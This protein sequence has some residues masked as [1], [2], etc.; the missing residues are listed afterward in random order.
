MNILES[1]AIILILGLINLIFIR[2]IS[3][4]FTTERYQ[5]VFWFE[6]KWGKMIFLRLLLS[7]ALVFLALVI[8]SLFKV[9]DPNKYYGF[10]T[11][12]YTFLTASVLFVLYSIFVAP[13]IS[14]AQDNVNKSDNLSL[15]HI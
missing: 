10:L 7:S 11:V 5:K 8:N 9:A 6:E 2:F 1:T 4:F 13:F 15:I 3:N 14:K 12:M